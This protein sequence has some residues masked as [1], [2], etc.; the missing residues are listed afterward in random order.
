[1]GYCVKKRLVIFLCIISSMGYAAEESDRVLQLKNLKHD[2]KVAFQKEVEKSYGKELRCSGWS[3]DPVGSLEL[4]ACA[5]ENR[6]Q[7][8]AKLKSLKLAQIYAILTAD[9]SK[10]ASIKQNNVTHRVGVF[11]DPLFTQVTFFHEPFY[12]ET[13]KAFDALMQVAKV[14]K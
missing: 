6:K 13:F 5:E 11:D 12:P 4:V 8:F 9:A 3:S 7:N 10:Y 14:K 1:M 2:L